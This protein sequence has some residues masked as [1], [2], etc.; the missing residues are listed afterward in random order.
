MMNN[1]LW[2]ISG[3]I[4]VIGFTCGMLSGCTP[5]DIS[6]DDPLETDT[7][8]EIPASFLDVEIALCDA[9]IRCEPEY[10]KIAGYGEFSDC[11][12][13]VVGE[14][15]CPFYQESPGA[16]CIEFYLSSECG[17]MFTG[18]EPVECAGVCPGEDP[19]AG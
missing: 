16:A 14:T 5:D 13:V 1:L 6:P 7:E 8:T 19:D 9:V 11:L 2:I 3:I 17:D 18:E 4:A 10:W 15:W 12:D